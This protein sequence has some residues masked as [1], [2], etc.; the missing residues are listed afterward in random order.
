MRQGKGHD[1][2]LK[3]TLPN[4]HKEGAS[5]PTIFSNRYGNAGLDGA[6]LFCTVKA[7]GG[8]EALRDLVSKK[9]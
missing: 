1:F 7:K 4:R 5:L 6:K 9:T 3:Y 8:P 2:V